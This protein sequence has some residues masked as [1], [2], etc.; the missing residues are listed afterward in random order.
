MTALL[1]L[2]LAWPPVSFALA[3]LVGRAIRFRDDWSL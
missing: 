1:L 2:L 3:V